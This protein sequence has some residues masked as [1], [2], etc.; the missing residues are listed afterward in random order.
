LAL[1]NF[2]QLLVGFT[3]SMAQTAGGAIAGTTTDI[4]AWEFTPHSATQITQVIPPGG[5]ENDYTFGGHQ[6]GVTY[7]TGFSNP[8]GITMTV[9]ATPWNQQTFYTERLLG[10]PFA[11]ENCIV[12]L[13]TGGNCIDYSVTCDDASGNQ[14]TCPQEPTDDIAICSQFYTSEPVAVTNT[15]FLEADPIGSNN[16]CSIWYSYMNNPIDGVVS[17][18]GT[19][20]SDVVATL[21][22]TGPGQQC[23]SDLK[24]AT[25]MMEKTTEK[26]TKPTQDQPFGFCPAIQ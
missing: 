13:Q 19:G 14:I 24:T 20:F 18:K 7:P 3:G 12:Y 15:D 6:F 16:W 25:K 26:Q 11:N 23:T 22:P 9:L 21:S 5:T 10:T 1:S 4:L 8:N 2:D 17:G